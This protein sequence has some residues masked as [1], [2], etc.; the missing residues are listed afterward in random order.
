MFL[1]AFT[2]YFSFIY[3]VCMYK[4]DCLQIN[5][6]QSI[7]CS[8]WRSLNPHTWTL[9][10]KDNEW[11]IKEKLKFD[12]FSEMVLLFLN[13]RF[14]RIFFLHLLIVRIFFQKCTVFYGFFQKS[15][16]HPV[17][18]LFWCLAYDW[19]GTNYRIF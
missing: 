18:N 11:K 2:S 13:V 16:D 4:G 9:N 15:F 10:T 8:C 3:N 14:L 12:F 5:L 6:K 17:F 19:Q 1:L 7:D